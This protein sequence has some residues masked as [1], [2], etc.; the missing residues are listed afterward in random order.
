MGIIQLCS[1]NQQIWMDSSS[2]KQN[3]S[4]IKIPSLKILS[5]SKQNQ[6]FKKETDGCRVFVNKFFNDSR[7]LIGIQKYSRDG[8]KEAVFARIFDKSFTNLLKNAVFLGI[9]C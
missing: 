9:K 7:E 8:S 6:I 2:E 3:L 1:I 5:C 4:N